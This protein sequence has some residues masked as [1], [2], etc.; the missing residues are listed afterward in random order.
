MA[1]VRGIEHLLHLDRIDVDPGAFLVVRP[2]IGEHQPHV[3]A[4]AR[5]ELVLV[6]IDA[7]AY[8]RERDGRWY[9]AV[10]VWV[11]ALVRQLAEEIAALAAV[12]VSAV[13][14][15]LEAL[16]KCLLHT[17]LDGRRHFNSFNLPS[18]L[19]DCQEDDC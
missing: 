7:F 9:D 6:R 17:L 1:N 13:R 2:R 16:I 5:H 12:F 3:V 15:G 11:F 19:H 14:D 8:V 10:V 18:F 4:E